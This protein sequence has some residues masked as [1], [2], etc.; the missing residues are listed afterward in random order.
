M[1]RPLLM[2]IA[3]V[4]DWGQSWEQIKECLVS[5]SQH[6][7]RETGG[8]GV[9]QDERMKKQV[10]ERLVLLSFEALPH[11]TPHFVR[12]EKH[13]WITFVNLRQT[14]NRQWCQVWSTS[15]PPTPQKKEKRNM[16]NWSS[17]TRLL[18]FY[19]CNQLEDNTSHKHH[20]NFS[21]KKRKTKIKQHLY[22][23][24]CHGIGQRWY[25]HVVMK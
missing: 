23:F 18:F 6:F 19:Y 10:E 11:E 17:P 7:P 24:F 12:G 8:W 5:Q 2:G 25:L 1:I 4:N 16:P 14:V 13:F 3:E 15:P 22:I 21:K 20:C 9:S